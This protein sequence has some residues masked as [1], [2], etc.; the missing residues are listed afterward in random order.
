M[1]NRFGRVDELNME[2]SETV[3]RHTVQKCDDL[4]ELKTICQALISCHFAMRK[5]LGEYLLHD[6]PRLGS[7]I[8]EEI[9]G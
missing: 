2:F 8:T 9:E 6:V 7:E 5:L 3:Q 1:I 4:N